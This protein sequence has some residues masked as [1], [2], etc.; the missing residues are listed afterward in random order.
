[1]A[2]FSSAPIYAVPHRK[3]VAVEHPMAIKNV[4]IGMKT[5]GRGAPL[6]QVSQELLSPHSLSL[7]TAV[8]ANYT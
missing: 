1:M 5:F 7:Y 3:V 6:A 2:T 8:S 4:D